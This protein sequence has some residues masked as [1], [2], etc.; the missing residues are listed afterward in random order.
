VQDAEAPTRLVKM[1][2]QLWRACGVLGLDEGS[3]WDVVRR[4]GLDSIPKLR[5][6]VLDV[7]AGQLMPLSTTMIAEAVEHP[8]R[9]TK[10]EL[11]D[12]TAHRVVR[13]FARGKGK[14]N[15]DTWEMTERMKGW[16]DTIAVP[17]LSQL[18]V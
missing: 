16:L 2:A 1:L 10:R 9:T 3:G 17:A 13:R 14:G 12:L 8:T 15:A 4:V 7:L 5:R 18:V 11:E 6:A